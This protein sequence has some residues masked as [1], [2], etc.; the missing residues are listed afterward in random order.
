MLIF[1]KIRHHNGPGIIKVPYWT[2]EIT[3]DL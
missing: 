1:D 3:I 2:M